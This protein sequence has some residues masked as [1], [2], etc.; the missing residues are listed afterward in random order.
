MNRARI[1]FKNSIL[2]A[3]EY[4]TTPRCHSSS[5][6]EVLLG[7]G[8]EVYREYGASFLTKAVMPQAPT[9]IF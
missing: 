9:Q 5:L 7:A 3:F 4:M 2:Y 6:I 8:S 1:N